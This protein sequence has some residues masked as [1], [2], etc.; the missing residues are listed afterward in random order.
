M[1]FR[2]EEATR[3]VRATPTRSNW[4]SATL[5]AALDDDSTAVRS[6]AARSLGRIGP[7][8]AAVAPRLIGLLNEADE[9]VRCQAAQALGE[10]GG[11]ERGD[12][13]GAGRAARGRRVPRS[14]RR[15]RGRWGR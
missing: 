12:G 3:A 14:R 5:E 4:P 2:V 9:T 10:V 1:V 15:R 11:D 8:A 13:G 6:Q 7:A